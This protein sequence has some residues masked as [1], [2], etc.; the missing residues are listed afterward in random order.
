MAFPKD[1]LEIG[2]N[3]VKVIATDESGNIGNCEA[4]VELV[5]KETKLNKKPKVPE[6]N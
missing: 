2:D 6:S 4:T 5:I 1:Q 3:S